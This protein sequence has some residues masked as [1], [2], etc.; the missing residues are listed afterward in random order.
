MRFF[1]LCLFPLLAWAA[2]PV[3]N[4]PLVSQEGKPFQLHDLKGK[5][6]LISFIF[7]RCPLPKM[8]PLTITRNKQ[9]LQLWK[10]QK[11]LPPLQLLLV[12]LDPEFDSPAVLKA[13]AKSRSLDSRYFTLATGNPGSLSDLAAEFNVMGFPSEGTITHNMKTVLLD[14]NLVEVR[15]FKENEWTADK[16][17]QAFSSQPKL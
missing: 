17:I 15:Q 11:G 10:K 16:V 8:C 1:L 9:V 5:P 6:V 2:E 4:F 12:T 13:F 7:T 3:K 14:A